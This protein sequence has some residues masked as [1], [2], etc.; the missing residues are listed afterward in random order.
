MC[1]R[2]SLG[3]SLT[4]DPG[5]GLDRSG[6][7]VELGELEV[8]WF[9]GGGGSVQGGAGRGAGVSMLPALIAATGAFLLL[10]YFF[11]PPQRL[12]TASPRGGLRVGGGLACRQVWAGS[13]VGPGRRCHPSSSAGPPDLSNQAPVELARSPPMILATGPEPGPQPGSGPGLGAA[14]PGW[15][16]RRR[17]FRRLFGRLFG[18]L[19]WCFR[20]LV[21]GGGGRGWRWRWLRL[22]RRCRWWSRW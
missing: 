2:C 15:L 4:G 20:V 9:A 14:G 7:V 12:F 1:G 22:R 17:L 3:C 18:G 10:N 6:G 13:A 8:G 11:T 19:R 16:G 5:G 21:V